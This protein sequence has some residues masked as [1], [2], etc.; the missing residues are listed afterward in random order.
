M[1]NQSKRRGTRT[2]SGTVIIDDPGPRTAL[3]GLDATKTNIATNRPTFVSVIP[4][5]GSDHTNSAEAEAKETDEIEAIYSPL[6]RA[7][8]LEQQLTREEGDVGAP[9][10]ADTEHRRKNT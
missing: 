5:I 3:Q 10:V 7:G 6:G 4:S 1:A 8:E 9:I 2:V